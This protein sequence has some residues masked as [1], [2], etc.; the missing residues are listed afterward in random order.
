[1]NSTYKTI[2]QNNFHR[3][4]ADVSMATI[5]QMHTGFHRDDTP[6]YY[7]L[8]YVRSGMGW[9]ILDGVSYTLEPGYMYMIPAGLS[10]QFGNDGAEPCEVYWCHFRPSAGTLPLDEFPV[11]VAPFEQAEAEQDFARLVQAFGS[12]LFTRELRVRAAFLDLVAAY[13]EV[14]DFCQTTP[15]HDHELMGKLEPVLAYIDSHLASNIGV[16]DLA[17]LAFLHPNYFIGYF[18]S[19]TGCSPI[20]YVNNRRLEEAR[21][22]LQDTDVRVAEVARAVGMQNHYLSRLFRQHYG[23]TPSRYR[24]IAQQQ[25]SKIG[26]EEKSEVE[27]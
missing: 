10:Q 7:R 11:A 8:W 17:K 27:G 9:L 2:L 1:M 16:Y 4:Q 21:R 22:L 23:L 6:D 20:Q 12:E 3:F 24:Q 26:E 19:V 5:S 15:L 25:R 13:L 18:K 14:C